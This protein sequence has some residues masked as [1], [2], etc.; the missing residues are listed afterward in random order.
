[1][2]ISKFVESISQFSVDDIDL[3]TVRKFVVALGGRTDQQK[4][5]TGYCRFPN[6]E[7]PK[8]AM[9]VP[10]REIKTS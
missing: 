6:A 1:M 5:D 2:S 10:I 7:R 3:D 9:I 4:G 8:R